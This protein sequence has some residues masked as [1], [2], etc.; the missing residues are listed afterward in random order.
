MPS[1]YAGIERT[2]AQDQMV[3]PLL[4]FAWSKIKTQE[5]AAVVKLTHAS[6]CKTCLKIVAASAVLA[7]AH[8]T[9]HQ[10]SNIK[11]NEKTDTMPLVHGS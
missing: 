6:W 1:V 8:P 5:E 2:P 9:V 10:S 11:I 3:E 7:K 4:R